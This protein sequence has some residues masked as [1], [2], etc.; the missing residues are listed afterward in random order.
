[1]DHA[2]YSILNKENNSDAFYQNL[3]LFTDIVLS[4]GYTKL[5]KLVD[6]HYTYIQR[7]PN[8]GISVSRDE[9]MLELIMV[10]VFWRNYISRATRVSS[11]S[12]W[13]LNRLYKF[14]KKYPS[15]KP[16]IDKVRGYLSYIFLSNGRR[17]VI[18]E[19]SLQNFSKLLLWMQATG[20]FNE[21][22]IRLQNWLNYCASASAEET[23]KLLQLAF[24]FSAYFNDVGRSMLGGYTENIEKFRFSAERKYRYREDYIFV[25]RMES[26]YFLNMFG[27]EIMNRQLRSDFTKTSYKAVL[28]PTCM[29]KR[30]DDECKAKSDGKERVCVQCDANCNIGKVAQSVTNTN[31]KVY[32]I[33][34][35]SG[36]SKFLAKWADQNETG[37]VGVACVLNLITGGYE[38]KRLNI[39]SQCVFLDYCGCKKHWHDKGVPT[40]INISQL[41]KVIN[42]KE[43]ELA[44]GE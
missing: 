42:A 14:R 39:A 7:K 30:T 37:L 5:G 43:L 27:A 44:V 15:L 38:M 33:P 19:Y 28:L 11:V 24:E 8:S 2:P 36:F 31:T 12:L 17:Y 9:F 1:M 4:R 21:E 20:E 35:S 16:N 25:N 32:L 26:E 18:N 3:E 22:Y 13:V 29:R 34:H 41:N 10:G 23:A 40:S 6:G